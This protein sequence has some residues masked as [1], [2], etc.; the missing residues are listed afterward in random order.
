MLPVLR[1]RNSDCG[2]RCTLQLL[3]AVIM[4]LAVAGCG[5]SVDPKIQALRD[6]LIVTTA[7]EG[8]ASFKSF[9][10]ILEADD[11]P[12]EVS[13][14]LRGRIHAG[15]IPPWEPGKAAFAFTDATGHDGED[16]HDPHTCPFCSRNIKDYL[17]DVY[18]RSADGNVI[19]VDSR[20]LFEVKEKQ[21]VVVEGV[22]EIGPDHR[23]VVNASRIYVRR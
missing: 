15:D 12:A 7:P 18:F 23:L 5:E 2:I 17:A 10:K 14:V 6:R 4:L 8:E 9:R 11:G 1:K 3:P 13:V 20:E 22:A 16:D 19:D 21:I